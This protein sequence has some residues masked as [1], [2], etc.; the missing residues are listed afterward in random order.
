MVV[1]Y[2]TIDLFVY[3]GVVT[4]RVQIPALL[5]T[6]GSQDT[7]DATF[8]PDRETSFEAPLVNEKLVH[9]TFGHEGHDS[10]IARA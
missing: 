7:F 8:H 6:A 9:P 2:R 5:P 3:I 4:Y 1:C 10:T